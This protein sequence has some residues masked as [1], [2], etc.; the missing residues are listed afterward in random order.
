MLLLDTEMDAV[1]ETYIDV[2][3]CMM[4]AYATAM[5]IAIEEMNVVQI[6]LK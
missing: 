2:L 1:K 4:K 5:R 3:L 6:Y